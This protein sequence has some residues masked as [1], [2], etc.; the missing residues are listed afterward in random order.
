MCD[1]A[2]AFR[3]SLRWLGRRVGDDPTETFTITATERQGRTGQ[4]DVRLPEHLGLTH[5]IE[6]S[7]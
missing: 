6:I 3:L 1:D 7:E 5:V 2:G 4:V